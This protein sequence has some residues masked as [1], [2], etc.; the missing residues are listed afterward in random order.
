M[1]SPVAALD[2]AREQDLQALEPRTAAFAAA[3]RPRRLDH[4]TPSRS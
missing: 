1:R 4:L 2:G 3:Q